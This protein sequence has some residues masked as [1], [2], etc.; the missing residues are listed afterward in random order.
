MQA[1][2]AATEKVTSYIKL[3]KNITFANSSALQVNDINIIHVT[4]SL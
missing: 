4:S 2:A 1:P 3:D